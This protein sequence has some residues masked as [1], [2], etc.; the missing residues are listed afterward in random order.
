MFIA[1]SSTICCLSSPLELA[2]STLLCLT[3]Y[4]IFI[5]QYVLCSFVLTGLLMNEN[6]VTVTAYS[7]C[8]PESHL[9]LFQTEKQIIQNGRWK[10][11]R[12][13]LKQ[14]L[15]CLTQSGHLGS[16]YMEFKTL[17]GI[18]FRKCEYNLWWQC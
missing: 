7:H 14:R 10:R 17:N 11:E 13:K 6:P 15:W 3:L 4:L 16:N 9:G 1:L 12:L 2:N 18:T 5:P 8:S